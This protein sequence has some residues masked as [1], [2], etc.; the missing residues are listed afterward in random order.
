MHKLRN[1]LHIAI[2]NNL[3]EKYGE[4]KRISKRQ[5]RI[6]LQSN[7]WNKEETINEIEKDLWWYRFCKD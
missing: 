2:L 6:I 3:L 7:N 5:M 1:T 4:S